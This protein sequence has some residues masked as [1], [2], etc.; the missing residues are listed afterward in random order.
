MTAGAKLEEL[1]SNFNY[2]T[3][4]LFLRLKS[5]HYAEIGQELPGYED[6]RFGE[7]RKMGEMRFETGENLAVIA[8]PVSG[9]LSERSGKKSQY[10]KA[11][12]ILRD[13]Q[14]Y[15][16][17]FFIFHDGEGNFRFSLVYAQFEG[18]RRNFSNFR[19]FTYFVSP[20]QTN[21]TFLRRVGE[22]DFSSL[23]AIKEAFSVEKVNKEFY[24]HI[25]DFFYRLTGYNHE[26]LLKLPS[27]RDDDKQT[28]QEFAVRLIGRA[29]FCWF[30]KHKRS[31]EGIPLIPESILSSESVRHNNGYYH[32]VLEKLFFEILNT[33]KEQRKPDILAGSEII[34]FLNG[35]LFEPHKDDFYNGEPLYNLV[36]PDDWFRQFFEVLEQYNFTIDENSPTDAEVSV[37]PEMLGRIFENLLAEVNP[38]TGETAR[39][40]TGS[41][42]T[43]R[44]IVDYMVDQSLIQYLKTRTGIDEAKLADLVSYE[45]EDVALTEAEK[46]AVF[47]ALDR[48]KVLD[49][50]CGSGAFPMGMLHKMLLALEKVDPRMQRWLK[51]NLGS[52]RDDI[53]RQEIL[54]KARLENWEY[55]RKLS[56]IQSAIYGVDIQP[57]A[58][59]ISKLRFFLSLVVDEQID[60][61][62]DNRG[63]KELPNLE[64][65]F[66]AA[67]AL[68]G[69]P[70]VFNQQL[71]FGN[72]DIERLKE[73]RGEY[74][75]SWGEDKRRIQE[76]FLRTRGK[77]IESSL[78]WSGKDAL[79]LQLAN[80]NPFENQATDWFDPEWMFGVREGFDVVIANPPY[81]RIQTLQ[82]TT[83]GLVRYLKQNYHSA[84]KGNYDVYV[85]FVEFGLKLLNQS[86]NL[87]FI[88]PHKFFNVRYGEPLRKILAE[89]KNL[90]RVVHF[91]HQQV[92]PGA[93]NYVCLLFLTKARGDDCCWIH[94]D[95]VTSWLTSFK[96]RQTVIPA[97]RLTAAE[98]NFAGSLA[99]TLIKKM[100]Q[101][102]TRLLDL[103]ASMSR[104]H[105]T[106]ADDVFI[107]E[108]NS[109]A[110]EE[111]ILRVPVFATDFARY[112]YVPNMRWRVIFPYQRQSKGYSLLSEAELRHQFPEAFSYLSANRQ[113][114]DQRKGARTWY[115]FSAARNLQLHDKAQILVSLLANTGSFALVPTSLSGR[116]CPMASGGFTLSATAS[117]YRIEYLLA[118]LNSRLL[119][120]MLSRTSNLFRGGWITC[121]KQYFGE[122]PICSL[123]LNRVPDRAEHDAIVSLV[124]RILAAKAADPAVDT[125]SWEREIDERVYRLYGLTKEEIEIVEGK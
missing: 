58:V 88:L 61:S 94:V 6:D 21:K 45:V 36:I 73:L 89:G 52:I 47:A 12:R 22:G 39:K 101:N 41:Y 48:I 124:D 78:K 98:W 68:I 125:S 75:R 15:D 31:A 32:Y 4:S 11:K 53:F 30:L 106:G 23:E 80:W 109:I 116:L 60:E 91:G 56:V 3:L 46:E 25:A 77:L 113:R 95:D 123:D 34:P 110:I 120:W 93:T 63:I 9:G 102:G 20:H 2:R 84:R 81:I 71:G 26:R 7:F 40:A 55:L 99:D 8:S 72:E 108:R 10:E 54:E 1:I 64:F 85:V 70:P 112:S 66:V 97:T 57:I 76:E 87:A 67:N 16:A 19:R 119:F 44:M 86:G 107:I 92:F 18:T 69:L 38:E 27:V 29:I 62:K 83:P 111:E 100:Q 51:Q 118:L 74:L 5:P 117:P 28:Y 114:L 105:S 115:G 79:A 17:G 65:K 82:K 103:P 50:A 33:P 43:P 13:Q 90:R 35:G 104:G 37:D 96:A 49:P 42:Y 24:K 121:T 14:I 122:L 59:E